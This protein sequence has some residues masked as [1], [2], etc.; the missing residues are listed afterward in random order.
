MILKN[1]RVFISET[2]ANWHISFH[3]SSRINGFTMEAHKMLDDLFSY[4]G[5]LA[6]QTGQSFSDF[7]QAN[8]LS[9]IS[10]FLKRKL[11]EHTKSYFSA[12][13]SV[14]WVL[15]CFMIMYIP[16][17]IIYILLLLVWTKHAL[18]CD[19]QFTKQSRRKILGVFLQF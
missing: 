16:F 4:R 15:Y 10:F 6:T 13:D 3:L 5:Y 11:V 7:T 18:S 17:M 12:A 2:C 14:L 19:V 9:Y 8:N 1:T